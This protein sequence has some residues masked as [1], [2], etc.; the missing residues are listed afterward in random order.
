MW[1]P[2][3]VPLQCETKG[4]SKQWMENFLGVLRVKQERTELEIKLLEW[5]KKCVK[6]EN[7][8]TAG[9]LPCKHYRTISKKENYG[10]A[11]I[12]MIHSDSKTPGRKVTAGK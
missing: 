6:R 3:H 8:M 1:H 10:V 9:V 4:K 12:K 5:S 11:K 7:R 2:K